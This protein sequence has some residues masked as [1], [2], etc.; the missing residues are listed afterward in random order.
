[1]HRRG[2]NS[3]ILSNQTQ[4]VGGGEIGGLKEGARPSSLSRHAPQTIK[5]TY[6]NLLILLR[7]ELAVGE[8]RTL[9]VLVACTD[10]KGR[11]LQF[12]ESSVAG[13]SRT[14]GIEQGLRHE[15]EVLATPDV[16][17]IHRSH[18]D[19]GKA[20]SN[21]LVKLRPV[22]RSS[23]RQPTNVPEIDDRRALTKEGCTCYRNRSSSSPGTRRA[24]SNE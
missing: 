16:P 2:A 19:I 11:E 15:G 23:H 21:I 17:V 4:G 5:T 8:N 24:T 3:Q 12:Q 10:E 22:N 7:I 14:V 20:N 13:I 1:M 18:K 6:T 9:V